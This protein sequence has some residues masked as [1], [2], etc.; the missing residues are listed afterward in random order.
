MKIIVYCQHVLGLGHFFR[1]LEIGKALAGHDLILVTGG[2]HLDVPLPGHM[3]EV[4]LDGLMMDDQFAGLQPA[5]GGLA[6]ETIRQRRQG[7]LWD[8]FTREAPAVFL[9]ELYPFGRKAFRFE[10]DPV[11]CGIRSG[12]LAPCRVVCSLR[13]VLV[14][15]EKAAAHEARTLEIL[16]AYFDGLLIHADPRVLTLDVTFGRCADIRV[17]VV[18]TGFVAPRAAVGSRS[19]LRQRLGLKP[20]DTL[21]VVSGGGGKVAG[22]LFA[23][24][25]AAGKYLDD[26][27]RIRTQMFTG[28]YLDQAAYDRLCR[29]QSPHLRVQRFSNDFLS[30]LVAADL[31][32]SM[33]GYNTCMNILAARVPALV[34]PFAQNREQ[35][36]R[37]EHLA[38]LGALQILESED[39]S[40]P[41][42]ADRIKRILA[43]PAADMVPVDLDGAA[44][45]AR[46]LCLWSGAETGRRP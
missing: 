23:A 34:W 24:V 2:Q 31:S 16:N 17:P 29:A 30:Y 6:L 15:K 22:P 1:T 28:P 12:S 21:V 32:I 43:S 42:L 37:A 19:M 7:A 41:R 40:A 33:A 5:S 3:R 35:R 11:L 27:G 46:Q 18:Y 14:E 38:R 39:L 36:L 45:T 25:A 20:K 26:Q 44:A 13:D 4:A 8:L 9:V 10:L